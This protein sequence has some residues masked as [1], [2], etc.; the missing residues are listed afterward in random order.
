MNALGGL[1]FFPHDLV[2]LIDCSDA[3]IVEFHR[4]YPERHEDWPRFV[5]C[6][7][8][9]PIF[10]WGGTVAYF[11]LQIAQ[12]M[13]FRNVYIIGVDLSYSIPGSVKRD[14]VVLTST[15]DDPNHYKPS[16]FGEGLRWHVP[17]PERMLR[18]FSTAAGMAINRNVANSGVGGNLDCFPRV[19]FSNHATG[20]GDT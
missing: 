3:V 12:W 19:P 16:Y 18:A 13:G 20:P 6:A 15:T 8:D 5:D 2:H 1:K 4:G 7:S 11:A 9:W 17:R 14:G 10:Y